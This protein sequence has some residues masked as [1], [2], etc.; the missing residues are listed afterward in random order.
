ML[1]DVSRRK[2]VFLAFMIAGLLLTVSAYYSAET[3]SNGLIRETGIR[4]AL[5]RA[6][7]AYLLAYQIPSTVPA[8]RAATP[9]PRIAQSVPVLLY[10]GED[11]AS[12]TT[13]FSTATFIDQMRTLKENGWRTVTMAQFLA[14][15]RGEATL[16]DRSFLLT[17][18][19]ARRDAYYATDPVLKDLGF[20]AVMFVITNFSMP[21]NGDTPI[22]GFYLSKA[23]LATMAAS[24]RW[25]IESHGA[26]DHLPYAVPTATSTANALALVPGE[27]FLS[28]LFWL[29]QK[30]RIETPAEYA[31]RVRQDLVNARDTLQEDF[32]TPVV[33]YAYPYNDFGQESVNYP[34][35]NTVLGQVVPS[36][37]PL[38]FYQTWAGNGDSFDYPDPAGYFTKR[39]EPPPT[40]DGQHLLAVLEGGRAK[41]LPYKTSSFG[42]DWQT[43]WGDA[44]STA[45]S[46]LA[47]AAAPDSTGAAVFLDG[48]ERWKNYR[49]DAKV[50]WQAGTISLIAR[51]TETDTPYLDCAF[52]QDYLYLERHTKNTHVTLARTPYA[53][54]PLPTTATISMTVDGTSASCDAYGASA[55]ASVTDVPSAGGIG[56]S[57]WDTPLGT[58]RSTLESIS[59][60]AL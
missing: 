29:P 36:I 59:V 15:E 56:A 51:H 52:S 43:N 33:A 42:V 9:I 13:P 54:P 17:F 24:G 41:A 5:A 35:A 48:T 14:F 28:N 27:H 60:Y 32:G 2:T 46:T 30:D 19:D 58:A 57:V 22:N 37:Y 16:P 8:A 10:H 20:T 11:A 45:S 12:I 23:E 4:L 7:L 49:I 44:S 1:F 21:D 39:I 53:P 6:D 26:Q 55:S 34:S 3:A 50:A 40:W 25:D 31:G 38:A 47:L 18:D